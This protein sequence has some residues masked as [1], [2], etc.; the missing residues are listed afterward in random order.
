[1]EA[2]AE[3]GYAKPGV[4]GKKAARP[5][6][7][8]AKPP[9]LPALPQE[10]LRM[11]IPTMLKAKTCNRTETGDLRRRPADVRSACYVVEEIEDVILDAL[12]NDF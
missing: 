12:W 5:H 1:M 3:A 4:A 7:S 10:T 2:T 8:E 6:L 9:S 11:H